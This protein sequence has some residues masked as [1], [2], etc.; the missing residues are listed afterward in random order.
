MDEEESDQLFVRTNTVK[1]V[2][3]LWYEQHDKII[4]QQD[5]EINYGIIGV[6]MNKIIIKPKE[7]I[8]GNLYDFMFWLSI[9]NFPLQITLKLNNSD[10][11]IITRYKDTSLVNTSLLR[12]TLFQRGNEYRDMIPVTF[13]WGNRDWRAKASL[14]SVAEY[15]KIYNDVVERFSP[16]NQYTVSVQLLSSERLAVYDLINSFFDP[17]EID[18]LVRV[19]S[20]NV[21]NINKTNALIENINS[22]IDDRLSVFYT[23]NEE[24]PLSISNSGKQQRIKIT[25]TAYEKMFTM[26]EVLNLVEKR[27]E[28]KTILFDYLKAKLTF[29]SYVARPNKIN[30]IYN[31]AKKLT[32]TII[33]WLEF[34]TNEDYYST[35][36]VYETWLNN[37]CGNDLRFKI[38]GFKKMAKDLNVDIS[39]MALTTENIPQL[40]Q[41]FT[42]RINSLRYKDFQ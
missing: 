2:L 42:K 41:L 9:D 29:Y 10:I 8:P 12:F 24:F 4:E 30:I 25:L 20:I 40:C 27:E 39:T 32:I 11:F 6:K 21:K 3:D 31:I 36:G 18:N 1:D 23:K 28:F 16:L 22:L 5:I 17:N 35:I 19:K 34:I 13:L 37:L 14:P 26:A 33:V 38:S 7:Q 15:K